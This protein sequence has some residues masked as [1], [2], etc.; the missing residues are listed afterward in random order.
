VKTATP[1]KVADASVIAALIFG[2]ERREEA[3]S[4]L[5]GALLHE[6]ALLGYELASVARK[7]SLRRPDRAD[8]LSATLERGLAL[9]IEW[10]EVDH[11]EILRLA[12]QTG[13][14]TYDATYLYVARSL[15]AAL[16]T[17]D[18]RII[19]VMERES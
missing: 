8:I 9:D 4:L 18:S 10:I 1:A 14:T 3:A 12:L 17:F 6:P 16:V 11:A 2:E 13:L 7:K 19:A 15:G 5:G